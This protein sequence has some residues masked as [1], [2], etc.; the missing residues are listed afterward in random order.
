MVTTIPVSYFASADIYPS[1]FV[2]MD[3][4]DGRVL[5]CVAGDRPLPAPTDAPPGSRRK[6]RVMCHRFRMGQALFHPLDARASGRLAYRPGKN[7]GPHGDRFR[8]AALLELSG[9]AAEC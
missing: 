8:A 9:G 6:V 5:Q 3:A 2:K 4:A 1:R 7:D